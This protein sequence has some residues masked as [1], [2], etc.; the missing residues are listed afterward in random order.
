MGETKDKYLD[1]LLN[2]KKVSEN[3]FLSYKRDVLKFEKYLS[4]RSVKLEEATKTDVLAYVMNLQENNVS[5]TT[6]S[7]NLA[8]LRS[9]Y[10]YLLKNRFIDKDPTENVK[11]YKTE[12]KLPEILTG[13]EVEILLSQPNEEDVLGCRDKAILE[14]LYATG[15]RTAEI[16]ELDVEN[17]NVE[18]GY[19]NCIHGGKNRVIPIYAEAAKA[20]KNYLG[21]GRPRLAKSNETALFLNYEGT[22]LSRQGFWKIIKQYAKKA[23]I[24]KPITPHTLRHSFAVHLLENGADLRSLQEM[25]GHSSISSTQLYSRIMKQRLKNVYFSAHPKAK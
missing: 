6:V 7:R 15:M 14:L 9:F 3:T 2:E 4:K 18:V 11:N 13:A 10:L 20:V 5:A 8:S 19:I 25:L 24:V 16:I 1:Y 12:R 17:V 22:R 21:K 23:K